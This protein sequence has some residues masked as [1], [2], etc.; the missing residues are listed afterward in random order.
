MGVGVDCGAVPNT[1][2]ARPSTVNNSTE[3]RFPKNALVPE[4]LKLASEW[5][6]H[7]AAP[8]S[9]ASVAAWK[10]SSAVGFRPACLRLASS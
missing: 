7:P 4:R 1:R 6:N 8:A 3:S 9:R 2:A 10:N 5:N